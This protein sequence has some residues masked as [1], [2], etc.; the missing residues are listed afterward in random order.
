M[1]KTAEVPSRTVIMNRLKKG[2]CT[3]TFIKANGS[4]RVMRCTLNED[5]FVSPAYENPPEQNSETAT[6]FD[7]DQSGWRSFRFDS[8]KDFKTA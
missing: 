8:V 5:L 7:L 2:E 3:I 4:K 1:T 6:V